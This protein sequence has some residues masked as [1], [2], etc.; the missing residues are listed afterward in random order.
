MVLG[1]QFGTTGEQTMK[2]KTLIGTHKTRKSK[3]SYLNIEDI[4]HRYII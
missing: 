2:A 1:M 3:R 4:G